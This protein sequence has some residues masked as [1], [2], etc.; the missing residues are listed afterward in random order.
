MFDLHESFSL[1]TE[2]HLVRL[3]AMGSGHGYNLHGEDLGILGSLDLEH[4]AKATLADVSDDFVVDLG[5]VERLDSCAFRKLVS[6]I[7]GAVGS[8][9]LEELVY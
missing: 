2:D 3:V 6:E 8:T 7:Y 9:F 4:T 5:D 1:F